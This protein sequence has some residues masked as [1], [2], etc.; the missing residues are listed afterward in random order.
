MHPSH[1]RPP[2]LLFAVALLT[3]ACATADQPDQAGAPATET[4]ATEPAAVTIDPAIL[5]HPGRSEDDH[6]RDQGFKPLEVYA[7]FGLRPGMV[8][9]DLMPGGGYNTVLLSQIVGE[10]GKVVA[11]LRPGPGGDP[12]RVARSR[13][14]FEQ[15]MAE[16]ALANVQIVDDPS[17]LPD[18]ALDLL[19][20]VRNYHDLGE[21]DQRLAALPAFLRILKPGGTFAVVDAYT[22]KTDERD[23]SV[24]RINDELA[25]REITSA[26][27]EFVAASDLLANPDDTY[28]FDGRERA[29]V[30]GATQDAPIH[31]YFIHRWVH[32]YRKP[33]Q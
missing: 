15:R 26:G 8:V 32:A 27:F 9:G 13:E 22:D 25:K 18:D 20:T 23:E 6:Y 12:E 3:T 1:L 5:D 7:F 28:D 24:H 33:A 19:L 14:R 11:I 21:Q 29:G 4:A 31:R 17:A 10:Q 16:F 2:S 30:R